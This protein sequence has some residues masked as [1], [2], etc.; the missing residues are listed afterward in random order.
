MEHAEFGFRRQP[1]FHG[2][3]LIADHELPRI[4]S[5]MLPRRSG[6]TPR[7]KLSEQSFGKQINCLLLLEGR[8][9]VL[10]FPILAMGRDVR[11]NP[12]RCYR[13]GFQY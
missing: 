1:L 6:L 9:G 5:D 8:N 2:R 10:Q 7:K 11:Y 12:Q 4:S 13:F 3:A